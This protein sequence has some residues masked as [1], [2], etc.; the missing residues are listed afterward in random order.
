MLLPFN[1]GAW[2]ETASYRARW[3][4]R[5]TAGHFD[6]NP[7]V[8][9]PPASSFFLLSLTLILFS[10]LPSHSLFAEQVPSSVPVINQSTQCPSALVGISSLHGLRCSAPDTNSCQHSESQS[11]RCFPGVVFEVKMAHLPSIA[12]LLNCAV[13]MRCGLA[14]LGSAQPSRS[15]AD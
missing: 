6:A 2:V 11:T 5:W 15:Q 8:T 14:H 1:P 12:W 10:R 13:A 9:S 3:K 4:E 7:M